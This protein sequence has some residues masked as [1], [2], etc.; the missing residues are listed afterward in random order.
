MTDAGPF[1]LRGKTACVVGGLGLI[2]KAISKALAQAGATVLILDVNEEAGKAFEKE[3]EGAVFIGFDATKIDALGAGVSRLY[4]E[5]GDIDIMVNASYPRTADWGTKIEHVKAESWRKNVDM[6]LN[7]GC[8]LMKEFAEQMKRRDIKGSIINLGSTYGVVAPDFE[9][10]AGT[11]MTCPAAYAAIKAGIINFTRYIAS[12]YGKHGIRA[13]A[14]CPGGIFDSQNPEFVKRYEA[15]TALKRMGRPEEIAG[16]AVFLAS[17]A[18]SYVTGSV[19][20][21]DGGWTSM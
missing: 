3:H 19:L 11:E 20:M 10:Y 4:E 8:L 15:R 12:Y 13:N 5:H 14:L 16:A 2:G 9:V 1:D 6:Q 18:A 7:S 17:E 21:V